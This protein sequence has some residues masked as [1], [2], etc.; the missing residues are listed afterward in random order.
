[1]ARPLAIVGLGK[2]ARD[3]HVPAIAAGDD[4]TLAAIASRN[5]KIAN[6]PS[7]PTLDAL[8]AAEPDVTCISL[9]TPPQARFDDARRALEA[10]RH[11][12]LEKPP[13]ATLSEVYSLIDLAQSQNCTLFAT[14]HSRHAAA[15][16][17]TR[18]WLQDKMLRDVTIRWKEDVRQWH[19]NQDWVWQAG[20]LGVFDPGI[21]A[22][23]IL[24]RVLPRAIHLES[25]ELVFPAN[26]ET[27][28]AAELRFFDPGGASISASFDWRAQAEPEWSIRFTTDDA[29]AGL[30]KGGAEL[31]VNDDLHAR[32]EDNEYPSL[33]ARFAHFIAAKESDVDLRPLRHVADAFMIGRR[34]TVDAFDW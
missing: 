34:T 26:R 13:G 1:M 14:W 23:S 27:P 7:Y 6:L 5:A 28:I 30:E 21:N 32:G 18:D 17:A 20:G 19:P 15:V 10:G 31:L 3:Q 4:F 9:C 11:V 2:I 8:L 22:L 25:A 12:M 24:T 33:Y 16:E 29:T